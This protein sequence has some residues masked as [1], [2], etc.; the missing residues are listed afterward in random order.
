MTLKLI[1]KFITFRSN[2]G[3]ALSATTAEATPLGETG[4]MKHL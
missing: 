3:Y 2:I 1:V 4:Q